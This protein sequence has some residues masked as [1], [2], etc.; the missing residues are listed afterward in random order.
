[1]AFFWFIT[2]ATWFI[3]L[4]MLT[5]FGPAGVC[6][7]I[8][9]CGGF[10]FIWYQIAFGEKRGFD[11]TY[12]SD[13]DTEDNDPFRLDSSGEPKDPVTRWWLYKELMDQ[14]QRDQ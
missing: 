13:D 1:M 9:V 14:D 6:L 12:D 8:P 10:T 5:V 7:V 3:G 11:Y 4:F 2:A